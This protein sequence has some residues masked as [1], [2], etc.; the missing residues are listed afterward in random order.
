MY[1]AGITTGCSP[2]KYCPTATVTREQMAGFL[3][4]GFDLS[5][6]TTDYFSDDN[7]STLEKEINALRKSGITTGC[8][9]GKYCPKGDVTR[10]QMA[11]F[12]VRALDLPPTT[13]DYF[14]DDNG[15]TFE[16][17]INALRKAGITTGC[18]ATH[19]CPTAK[20]SREQMAG[21][22]HRALGD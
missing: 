7:T 1:F 21:F 19:Y 14:V 22:L 17:D 12:L 18:D 5:P 10:E 13:T 3:V 15:R 8:A 6:T 9:V 4:R 20:V 11:G 16:D 2:T